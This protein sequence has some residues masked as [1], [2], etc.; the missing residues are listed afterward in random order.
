MWGASL[1]AVTT[2]TRAVGSRQPRAT[3]S[4]RDAHQRA[5]GACARR[6]AARALFI[7]SKG[8]RPFHQ[9]RP[10]PQRTL[11]ITPTTV[12]VVAVTKLRKPK[13]V[14]EIPTPTTQLA[15]T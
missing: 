6:S 11:F 15:A 5:G 4:N 2:V 12:N 9:L 14:K 8:S 10:L 3:G 13:P 1:R 7:T